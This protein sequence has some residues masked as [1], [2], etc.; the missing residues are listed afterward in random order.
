MPAVQE[1]AK[2][3]KHWI[4][5][6]FTLPVEGAV[7]SEFWGVRGV[8]Q[9]YIHG[10]V[11]EAKTRARELAAETPGTYWVVYEAQWYAFTDITPVTLRRVGE[12]VI[13]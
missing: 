6:A 10:T 7:G 2:I 4:V 1:P 5:S 3:K 11:E 9:D 13:A 12:A 8:V